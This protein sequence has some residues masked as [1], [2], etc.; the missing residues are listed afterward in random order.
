MGLLAAT[1]LAAPDC[2]V[3]LRLVVLDPI[4]LINLSMK[5][6]LE[7]CGDKRCNKILSY[8][9]K[10][11]SFPKCVVSKKNCK[12]VE[13]CGFMPCPLTKPHCCKKGS[14]PFCSSSLANCNLQPCGSTFCPQSKPHCCEN[15]EPYCSA[16]SSCEAP[17]ANAC[18]KE[19]CNVSFPYCC[20]ESRNPS[21]T[22][23]E[24]DCIR[25]NYLCGNFV[26]SRS[27]PFCC[28]IGLQSFC[29]TKDKCPSQNVKIQAP[30]FVQSQS[31]TNDTNTYLFS[32][33]TAMPYDNLNKTTEPSSSTVTNLNQRQEES[34][35]ITS[36]PLLTKIFENKIEEKKD[37]LLT[38]SK[39]KDTSIEVNANNIVEENT[40]KR[41]N[42]NQSTTRTT[43][44]L[45][46]ITDTTDSPLYS[47]Y[48]F[49]SADSDV[50][51]TS[52][53]TTADAD[54]FWDVSTQSLYPATTGEIKNENNKTPSFTTKLIG[55]LTTEGNKIQTELSNENTASE[56]R[57]L[58]NVEIK[59]TKE[60]SSSSPYTL[61]TSTMLS[62][63]ST[64]SSLLVIQ[65]SLLSPTTAFQDKKNMETI[66]S[67]FV[68]KNSNPVKPLLTTTKKTQSTRMTKEVDK[69]K[70]EDLL[71]NENKQFI[72][73][74]SN[75]SRNSCGLL[76]CTFPNEICCNS[77]TSM[78]CASENCLLQDQTK[79][80]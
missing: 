76:N 12:E 29:T 78:F 73:A 66:L 64:T 18:G 3:R 59:R 56:T 14:R 53:V 20:N 30:N 72:I 74:K 43:K 37:I 36:L 13:F 15:A 71:F 68:S 75:K 11:G 48:N 2:L 58:N 51:L 42:I 17:Q 46:D 63:Q 21:C 7:Q 34:S 26:C 67:G 22:K 38:R 32:K 40:T 70:D 45:V 47:A 50:S 39:A 54:S 44:I 65:P 57:F 9:C 16:R 69:K 33:T 49:T 62:S 8:C 4:K 27:L 77:G 79:L 35:K 5:F 52:F 23:S 19:N 80:V 41:I 10:L 25:R 24:N 60:S 61:S 31:S 28:E 6:I 55:A 1:Q